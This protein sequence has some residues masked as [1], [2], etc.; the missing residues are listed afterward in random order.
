MQNRTVRLEG[1]T[2][3][4]ILTVGGT[5]LGTSRDK[6]RQMP[7]GGQ[8]LDMTGVMVDTYDRCSSA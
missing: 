6:P 1:P 8:E 5:I 3:S 4:G 7:V 2:P